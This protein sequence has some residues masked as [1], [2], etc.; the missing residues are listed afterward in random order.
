MSTAWMNS[1]SLQS[2]FMSGCVQLT[3]VD[4]LKELG[5]LQKLILSG[6]SALTNVACLEAA[7]QFAG[8]GFE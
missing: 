8:V 4:G 3:N 6:C 7:E 1:R 5:N 2:L